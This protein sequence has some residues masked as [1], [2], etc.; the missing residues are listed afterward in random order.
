MQL[1][2]GSAAHAASLFRDYYPFRN[3]FLY[4]YIRE[5]RDWHSRIGKQILVRD[6]LRPDKSRVAL[7]SHSHSNKTNSPRATRIPPRICAAVA[8]DP[9]KSRSRTVSEAPRIR[10]TR[11]IIAI[12]GLRFPP[13]RF[14]RAEHARP[15]ELALVSRSSAIIVPREEKRE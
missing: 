12:F 10:R 14:L 4:I 3:P 2:L 5:C 9:D 8:R 13:D 6:R 15:R 1:A 11:G 7:H